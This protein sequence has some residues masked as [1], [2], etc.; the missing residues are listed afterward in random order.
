MATQI[1]GFLYE[2]DAAVMKAGGYKTFGVRFGLQKLH[3]NTQLYVG[4]QADL[5]LPARCF[6]IVE[7]VGFQKKALRS[8]SNLKKANLTVRN[9]PNSVAELR[10]R[11]KLAE[12]GDHY[13]F[14]CTTAQDEKVIIVTQKV[15]SAATCAR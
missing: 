9:F 14:A 7:V 5:A 4:A 12:G 8:I 2:P 15:T 10:K 6:R 1:E 11:L 13:L 3:P